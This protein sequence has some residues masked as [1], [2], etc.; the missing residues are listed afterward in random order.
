VIGRKE[1]LAC[2][3][4]REVRREGDEIPERSEGEGRRGE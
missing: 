2:V 4:R 1:L 3:I